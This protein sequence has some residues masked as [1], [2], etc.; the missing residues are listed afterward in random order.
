MLRHYY[1]SISAV[2]K[3]KIEVKKGSCWEKELSHLGD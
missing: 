3:R 1:A 2:Y